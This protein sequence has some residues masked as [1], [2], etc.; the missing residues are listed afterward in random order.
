MTELTFEPPG[1]HLFVRS[2]GPEGIRIGDRHFRHSIVLGRD[3]MVENWGPA[4]VSEL[5][6]EHFAAVLDFEP[7]IVLL[8]TGAGQVVL[9]PERLAPF[10][11][12][13]IGVEVMTTQAACRTFNVLVSEQREVVAALLPLDARADKRS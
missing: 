2:T 8:G 4:S 13:A 1:E 12:R 9:P 11:R 10:H 3:R 5:G 7:E 6:E